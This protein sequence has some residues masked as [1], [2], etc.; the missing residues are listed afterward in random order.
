MQVCVGKRRAKSVAPVI[1]DYAEFIYESAGNVLTRG[2][3]FLRGA[4]NAPYQSH[5]HF[6]KAKQDRQAAEAGQQRA[7]QIGHRSFHLMSPLPLRTT[8]EQG[9]EPNGQQPIHGSPTR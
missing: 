8:G 9:F 7:M 2:W 4:S 1:Q 6:K 5:R 3:D